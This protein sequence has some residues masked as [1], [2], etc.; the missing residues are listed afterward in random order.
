M[1]FKLRSQAIVLIAAEVLFIFSSAFWD[2][3]QLGNIPMTILYTSFFCL[4][5]YA[6]SQ[7]LHWLKTYVLMALGSMVFGI[8][9][10]GVVSLVLKI[11]FTSAAHL[12]LFKVV[13]KHSFFTENVSKADRILAGVAGYILLGL[14]WANFFML[15]GSSSKDAILNQVSGVATTR[16]EEL[17]YS[18]VTITSLGYGD[19]V[20]VSPMAKVV[21]TFAGL[22]GVL[23]TAIF[24][25][26]LI[27]SL[28]DRN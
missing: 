15:I 13:L 17:Y 19:I 14:F 27:S 23:Y 6:M 16:A 11:C 28:R 9:D 12:L 18:F 26:A 5:G 24:I 2:D 1:S 21:A 7:S 3:F 4:G 10:F 8:I 25:S 20:P 22:S